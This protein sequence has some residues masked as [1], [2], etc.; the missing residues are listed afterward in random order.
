MQSLFFFLPLFSAQPAQPT[1]L[2]L[3]F[4]SSPAAQTPPSPARYFFFSSGPARP[5]LLLPQPPTGG[6]R[7]SGSSPSRERRGLKESGR[8]TPRA[9]PTFL[10]HTPR[11]GP[12]PYISTAPPLGTPLQPAPQPSLANPSSS[13]RAATIGARKLGS[14]ASR[15]SAA[16]PSSSTVAEASPCGEDSFLLFS[17]LPYPLLRAR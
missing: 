1:S 2:S 7:L 15:R 5:G 8:R 17:P 14:H 12:R 16:S 3:S 11:P 13:C 9:A 10:A 4:F 6:P